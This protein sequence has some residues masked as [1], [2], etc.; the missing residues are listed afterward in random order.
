VKYIL[1]IKWL[2]IAH[3][4]YAINYQETLPGLFFAATRGFFFFALSRK[5]EKPKPG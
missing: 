5:E 3:Y 4:L 1:R 2:H